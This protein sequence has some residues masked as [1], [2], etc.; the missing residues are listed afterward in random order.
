MTL[1]NRLGGVHIALARGRVGGVLLPLDVRRLI[2]GFVGAGL[3]TSPALVWRA[4]V[5]SEAL[6]RI[7]AAASHFLTAEEAHLARQDS[8]PQ[9]K[10]LV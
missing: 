2:V 7:L 5:A 6:W 8:E 3:D 4:L 10:C 1:G 9:R